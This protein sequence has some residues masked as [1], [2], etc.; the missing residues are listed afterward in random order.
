MTLT[1]KAQQHNNTNEN[2]P[3]QKRLFTN[4]PAQNYKTTLY[5]IVASPGE[6]SQSTQQPAFKCSPHHL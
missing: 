4:K 6:P 5:L 2:L 1:V 3:G